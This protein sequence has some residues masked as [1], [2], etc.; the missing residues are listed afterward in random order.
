MARY[1][2]AEK[3]LNEL[4]KRYESALS[5][6]ENV[7]DPDLKI[8]AEQAVASFLE[9]ILTIKNQPTARTAKQKWTSRK[10]M[11]NREW[12]ATLSSKELSEF[13]TI[14][15]CVKFRQPIVGNTI[16]VTD[17]VVSIKEISLRY[18]ISAYG[19]EEWLKSSQEFEVIK[20]GVE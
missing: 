8:R 9:S 11:T 15:L 20:Q 1:I 6:Y 10:K 14:G 7:R 16:I 5:W 3:L 2:D 12:L 18:S 17:D 13:L 19:V 4:Q